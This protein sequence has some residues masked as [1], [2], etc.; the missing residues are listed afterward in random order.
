VI[1]AVRQNAPARDSAV[2]AAQSSSAFGSIAGVVTDRDRGTPLEGAQVI[3]V[4]TSYGIRTKPN[5]SYEILGVPPGTYTIKVQR[6]G[7]ISTEITGVGVVADVRRELNVAL[8]LD[9]RVPDGPREGATR[10]E[11]PQP[12]PSAADPFS[13]CLI[14]PE[15]V[16]RAQSEI[17]LSEGQRRK[18][19]DEMVR[20]QTEFTEGQWSM[21]NETQ[22]LEALLKRPT[23]DEPLALAQ[24]KSL[25]GLEQELK[26]AQ[27]ALLVRVRNALAPKQIEQLNAIRARE[28]SATPAC[29]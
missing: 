11:A 13:R 28:G 20:A 12:A 17:G 14:P 5:G 25:M 24:L 2:A 19:I 23:I 3:A 10:S 8:R 6:A 21:T 26:R 1:E 9:S 27:F 15:L 22:K 16:M 29:D 7:Y 4:G 18:I